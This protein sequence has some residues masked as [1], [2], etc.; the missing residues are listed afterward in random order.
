MEE[1]KQEIENLKQGGGGG[2]EGGS[3]DEVGQE[4]TKRE[5]LEK[6]LKET[7]AELEEAKK[8]GGSSSIMQIKYQAMEK[9]LAKVKREENGER[10]LSYFCAGEKAIGISSGLTSE[11]VGRKRRVN[12][13]IQRQK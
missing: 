8:A 6:M 10:F 1:A 5:R 2:G 11:R 7:K 9:E 3:S 13:R 4:R 12:Q